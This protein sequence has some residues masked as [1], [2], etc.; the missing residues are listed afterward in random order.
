MIYLLPT[1]LLISILQNC[2][3][4]DEEWK[5]ADRLIPMKEYTEEDSREWEDYKEE[6]IPVIR[7]SFDKGQDALLI[8]VPKLV[9]TQ[10]HYI[11]RFGV[12]DKEGLEL[13]SVAIERTNNPLSYGYIPWEKIE[14][15]GR[16]KAYLKCNLHDTWTK[17]FDPDDL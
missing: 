11:E 9:I 13:Y 12:L 10:G 7:K 3:A 2:G 5:K 1:I 6:H 8:E 4:Q 16:L 17:E 14:R 15:K